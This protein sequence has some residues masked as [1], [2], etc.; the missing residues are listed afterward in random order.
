MRKVYSGNV[1]SCPQLKVALVTTHLPLN[2]VSSNITPER[3]Q[4]TLK[5]IW[6]DFINRFAIDKPEILVCGLNPHAGE[7]GY[8]GDEELTIIEPVIKELNQQ[9]LN[10]YGPVSADTAFSEANRERFDV[11]VCMYHDQGL[12]VLKTLGF[13]NAVNITLGLPI[14]RTSVD[15]GTALPLAGSGTANVSSLQAAIN[16]AIEIVNNTKILKKVNNTHEC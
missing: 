12:P 7:G 11:F 15:H 5:V 6:T 3:L 4:N 16:L 8:L 13:G 1:A 14:I 9:G 2:Q 10:L